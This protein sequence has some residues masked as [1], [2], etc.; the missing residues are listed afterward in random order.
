MSTPEEDDRLRARYAAIRAAIKRP[1]EPELIPLSD[2]EKSLREL[3]ASILSGGKEPELI[4]VGD[5][6][7]DWADEDDWYIAALNNAFRD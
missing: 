1:R 6:N 2:D 7:Y 3:R 5:S 4:D